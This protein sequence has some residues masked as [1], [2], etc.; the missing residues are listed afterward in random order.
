MNLLE[1]LFLE[2]RLLHLHSCGLSQFGFL[3]L[4]LFLFFFFTN[5]LKWSHTLQSNAILIHVGHS[6]KYVNPFVTIGPRRSVKLIL[7]ELGRLF[8]VVRGKDKLEREVPLA[9]LDFTVHQVSQERPA[10]FLLPVLK[11]RLNFIILKNLCG[12]DRD[13]LVTSMKRCVVLFL[14]EVAVRLAKLQHEVSFVVLFI[15]E[16]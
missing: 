10:P 7:F 8:G 3:V 6:A 4:F 16:K 11:I 14:I 5:V 9:M 2:L 12:D 13:L 15:M 1:E